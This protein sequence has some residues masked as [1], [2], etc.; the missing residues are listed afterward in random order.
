MKIEYSKKIKQLPPY[1][2][3]EIDRLKEEYKSKGNEVISV[4][5]GDPDLPTPDVII[6]ALNS[7]ARDSRNHQYPSYDGLLV[8]R[9]KISDWF[10]KRYN[11]TLSPQDEILSLIGSKE[12]IGHFPFA[13]VDRDD[14][15]LVPDPG[16]PVYRS[17]TIFAEGIPYYMPLLKENNFLPD[18]SAIPND[19]KK[20]A[21]LMFLNYPNNPTSAVADESFFKSVVEFAKENN[22]IVA[23]DAAYNELYFDDNKPLS[24]LQIEGAM[25]IAVEFHSL[26]KTFNMTGW[27]IG[28]AAGNKD[29]IKGLGRIKSN[30]D[31]GIFQA[32]QYAAIAALENYEQLNRTN[33]EI[34]QKRRDYACKRLDKLGWKYLKPQATFYLWIETIKGY[35]SKKM[36]TKFLQ[37]E[38][39]VVTPGVGFGQAGEGYIRM[40]LTVDVKIL[41]KVFNKIENIKW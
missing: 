40:A 29:I 28:F 4:G 2:F 15:V 39:I 33:R 34:F 36:A 11:V 22:I 6:D 31:S 27:R 38:G 23:H 5:I 19:V 8:F 9:Q 3:A 25:D 41:E 12:G 35:D 7:A 21:K 26:S 14:H 37:D 1:L 13:F 32:V 20:S 16:Y 30:L 17:G 10:I 24:F 18:L